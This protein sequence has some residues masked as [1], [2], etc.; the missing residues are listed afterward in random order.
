MKGSIGRGLVF[1]RDKAATLD[2]VGFVDSDYAGD[3]DRRRSILGISSL[4]V[5]VLSHGKH[6]FSLL[7]L[8][9]LRMLS[10]LLH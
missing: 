5:Q 10:I 1:D 2:V 3:L 4:C 6:H 7:Q 8:F 9:L